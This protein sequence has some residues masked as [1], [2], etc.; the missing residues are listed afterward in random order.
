ML[1]H[2][3]LQLGLWGDV[4]AER[5]RAHRA[6][7]RVQ[8]MLGPDSV[9]TAVLGGGRDP[10]DQVQLVPWGDERLPAR[11]AEPPWPGRLPAPSPATVL[12]EVTPVDVTDAD[13]NPVQ[14]TARLAVTGVPARLTQDR[15]TVEITGWAGPWPVD[16]RWWDPAEAIRKA[17]FQVSLSDG[18]ALLLRLSEG[19][20]AIEAIYD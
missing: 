16:E 6:M 1:A 15:Q 8:G 12:T 20:W 5:D 9:V 11:P 14:V 10:G 7:V 2:A 19:A 17:R 3:G 13:G 18:R 4:G